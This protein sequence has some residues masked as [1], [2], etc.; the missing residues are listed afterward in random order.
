MENK[1]ISQLVAS[2]MVE[3]LAF[4]HEKPQAI[5]C[6]NDQSAELVTLLK[7]LYPKAWIVSLPLQLRS[8]FG[9]ISWVR[10]LISVLNK[11]NRYDQNNYRQRNYDW[12]I[13]NLGLSSANISLDELL[14]LARERL[15]EQGTLCFSFIGLESF[16]SLYAYFSRT[17]K[18]KDIPTY[19]LDLHQVGDRLLQFGFIEPVISTESLQ[20]IYRRSSTLLHDLQQLKILPRLLTWLS[21]D[22]LTFISMIKRLLAMDGTLSINYEFVFAYALCVGHFSNPTMVSKEIKFY[23]RQQRSV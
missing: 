2:L 16:H 21:I 19:Q 1:N 6:L 23:P 4:I 20:F 15:N 5:A 8:T 10:R 9:Q 14:K 13:S 12:L 3:R 17:L 18:E 22:Q 7:P 11:K